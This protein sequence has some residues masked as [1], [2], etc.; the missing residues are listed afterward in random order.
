[1]KA[2]FTLTMCWLTVVTFSSAQVQPGYE[3]N[4]SM[5]YGT[6]DIRTT[7]SATDYYYLQE[8]K[9]FSFRESSPGVRTNTY[10]DM[11]SWD[12]SPYKEGNLRRKTGS[13]DKFIMNYRLLFPGGYSDT[14]EPGYPMLIH[15]HG[16]V[17]RANC[18][19]ENCFHAT[20]EYTVEEN[21]PPAPTS[22]T[23]RL[24]N[25]DYN[26][27]AGGRHF[28]D[29]RNLAGTRQPDDPS[30]P[31]RAFPGFVLSAQMFNIWDSLQVE[32]VVRIIRLLAEKYQVDEDRIYV[33]GLSI[34]GYAVYESMKRASWLVAAGFPMSSVWDANIFTQNQQQKVSHIP[35]WVFQGANDTRPSPEFT[36]NII[37][38]YEQA[39]GIVRYTK[40]SNLAHV[41]W[42]SAYNT[43]DFYSWMLKQSKA[44]LHASGGNTVINHS[45]GV[46]PKLMLAEGFL[47]Y[48]W[49]KDGAIIGHT[50]NTLTVTTPASTGPGSAASLL[51]LRKPSGTGGRSSSPSRRRGPPDLW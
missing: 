36:E 17:E 18:Y 4:T 44:N 16:A 28:M 49:E 14:Y 30:M 21:S 3:Y 5:P 50:A 38:Q 37:D 11:T 13:V 26:L 48:Q 35:L 34:G 9:T 43:T 12:S 25:N 46:Y 32:D 23:H 51:H 1:M 33:Q 45:S 20:P 15:M 10:H 29:A 47:A 41:V 7:I 8:N 6:L 39:G 31:T 42:F 40:Y 19:Y 2:I 24:L 22:A 27:A